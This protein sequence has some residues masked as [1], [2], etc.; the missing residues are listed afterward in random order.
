MRIPTIVARLKTWLASE[1]PAD[2]E[3]GVATPSTPDPDK[4]EQSEMA[5]P[6]L[7]PLT[8]LDGYIGSC[9]VDSDS[10]MVL[11][12]DGGGGI[13]DMETAA[14]ANTQVVSAKRRAIKAL[15]LK[16]KIEDILI[17]LTR[18]YHLIRPLDSNDALFVYVALDRTK[19]NLG[20]ARVELKK[21]EKG[22]DFS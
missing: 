8:T 11:A 3:A 22:L 20:L 18:Q 16:E 9:L 4:S 13:L 14:A 10:G 17:S 2:T 15:D 7:S 6:N 1:E 19:A 12:T 5:Q 21:F